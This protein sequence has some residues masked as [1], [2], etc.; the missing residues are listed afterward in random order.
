[1]SNPTTAPLQLDRVTAGYGD[2]TV[3]RDIQLTVSPGSIVAL[4]GPNG[5]GKT[6]LLRVASGLLAPATGH[7]YIGGADA[8]RWAPNR[9]SRAGLCLIPEGRG[10]FRSLSVKE[11]LLMDIRKR[12]VKEAVDQACSIFPV[13]GL[14]LNQ[15]AGTLSGGQQQM[16]SIARAYVTDPKVVLLDE[17]SMG[18][19]PI[20]T[21]E[22][23]ASI[24]NLSQSGTALVLVEQYVNQALALADTAVV[25][26]RGEIV[27]DGPSSSLDEERL[28][29]G[30]LGTASA[31]ATS[32]K[33]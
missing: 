3:L 16:L 24:K 30:Y 18:L 29:H 17:V 33:S 9:R 14:R 13:L 10:V 15:E 21:E 27:Y 11:N 8:T 25:L 31:Y 1:M 28:L 20:I 4:L 26:D 7:V 2:T 19:A 6:T 12:S 5:A 23:Y 22:I 32:P